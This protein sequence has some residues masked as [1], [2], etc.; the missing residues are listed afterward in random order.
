MTRLVWGDRNPRFY[1]GL[2]RGVVYL[3]DNAVVWNGLVSMAESTTESLDAEYYFD[4]VR[5][6]IS[7]KTGEFE[8][9]AS[10][11]TY[12]DVFDDDIQPFGLSYRVENGNGHQIHLLY[13]VMAYSRIEPWVTIRDHTEPVHFTWDIRG[14]PETHLSYAPT[15]HL[16][17]DAG[18]DPYVLDQLEAILYG[19]DNTEPRLPS[20]EELVE[21]YSAMLT[22]KI[23]YHNDGTYTA[24]G[25]DSVVRILGDGRFELNTPT[26]VPLEAGRFVVSSY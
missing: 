3:A 1:Q 15:M 7:T 9:T 6:H 14:V 2:D 4:G 12:P 18:E 8:A 10:A 23:T 5:T 26:A 22:L 20:P 11:F 17:L 21:L 13:N 19:D 25:P 24:E 16:T